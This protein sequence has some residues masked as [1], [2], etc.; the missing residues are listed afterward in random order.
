MPPAARGI[1]HGML[2]GAGGLAAEYKHFTEIGAKQ[3]GHGHR[4][5][6]LLHNLDPAVNQQGPG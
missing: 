3:I 2:P 6:E 4:L 1:K 5:P